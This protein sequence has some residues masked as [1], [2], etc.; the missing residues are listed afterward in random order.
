MEQVFQYQIP[1]VHPLAVHF[2]IVLVLIGALS[3]ILWSFLDKPFWRLCSL[4]LFSLGMVGGLAAYFTGDEIKE[5]VE[6]TPIVE[7]LVG[8]HEDAALL[9]LILTGLSLMG[10]IGVS[11]WERYRPITRR[12]TDPLVIRVV[13]GI[14]ALLSAI[15]V[16]WT[17]YIGGTMV[18]GIAR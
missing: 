15:S 5:S 6:G 4:F 1:V 8:K 2:P 13:M 14:L 3:V 7:E 10:L 12:T 11:I 17:A 9:F 18:W 16:I